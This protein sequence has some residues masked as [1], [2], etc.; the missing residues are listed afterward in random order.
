[1]TQDHSTLAPQLQIR[2]DNPALLP[3]VFGIQD[4][5]LMRL[6]RQL[7]VSIASRGA[8]VTIDG[9][10]VA[11]NQARAALLALYQLAKKNYPITSEDVDDQVRLGEEEGGDDDRSDDDRG[12]EDGH[13]TRPTAINPSEIRVKNRKIRARGPGQGDYIAALNQFELVF[14]LGP[15]GSG[16]TW[17]AVAKGVELLLAGAVERII[18]TRPA[19]E[20]GEHLGFLPGDLREKIDPYLRPLFDALHDMLPAD[21]INRRLE[22]GE[23]EIAPLAFMRGRT[24]A[25]AYVILDEAQNTTE[26]QMKMFLTRMGDHSR[27]VVTGDPSQID[28]PRGTASG[29]VAAVR[30]LRDVKG[31]AMVT[32]SER[33]IVRHPL[34]SRIVA[35]YRR[36]DENPDKMPQKSPI[37]G[38]GK[39]S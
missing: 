30:I 1:M 8:I 32:L 16:K 38:E 39:T 13:P 11:Q 31:A 10:A 4:C 15:A 22:A 26:T 6:E 27:M 14:G 28:L 17:L 35:A 3:D 20:A 9:A 33:D 29:L 25:K 34:V 37:K 23:I 18:L 2:F 24:L 5:H 7:S 21:Q 12:Y 19:V 36:H